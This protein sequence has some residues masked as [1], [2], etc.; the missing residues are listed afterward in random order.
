M[1]RKDTSHPLACYAYTLPEGAIRTSPIEPRDST[2]LFVYDTKS[3]T[4]S[5][6]YFY[7]LATYIPEHTLM[8][9]NDTG[10]IP[11]RV[12]FK[13]ETGGKCNGLVLINEGFT[14]DGCIPVIVDRKIEV[15]KTLSLGDVVFT[16]MRQ[17][18]QKFFLRC[19]FDRELLPRL[20]LSLG[21]T[22]TP[23]YLGTQTLSEEELRARYQTIFAQNKRSV[24][25]PTASL[26]FTEK[27]FADLLEK[28]VEK[29]Y[30]T[31]DVGMGTFA[32]VEEENAKEKRLHEETL[33]I[34]KESCEQLR[35][36]KTSGKHILS[37]GTTATRTLESQH[38]RILLSRPEDIYAK[39]DMFIMPPYHFTLPTMMLTNF[40][41]PE[42]SLMALVD[43]FLKDKSAKRGI[44]EL[45]ELAIREGF[46]FY[47]FGDSM[48][49]L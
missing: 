40:H 31:L 42:S 36:A 28:G 49:I 29:A 22:P 16:V 15:G 12:M 14:D 21:T 11:A 20:L 25:A 38:E 26:H 47:S 9:L 6:D 43:A 2:R 23:L 10:V 35:T 44:V 32:T 48:L 17:E 41:V 34:S 5:F 7:N 8:V 24:A 33:F 4:V 13:K 1:S 39:T 27:V 37:V 30:V 45:Y 19:E 3:D 18:E 46:S